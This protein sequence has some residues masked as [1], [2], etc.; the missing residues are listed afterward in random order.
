MVPKF[1]CYAKTTIYVPDTSVY[2]T[3]CL[4]DFFP[5]V[6]DT[7]LTP[8]TVLL[9]LDGAWCRIEEL[10]ALKYFFPKIFIHVCLSNLWRTDIL[11]VEMVKW[12]WLASWIFFMGVNILITSG[13]VFV[14]NSISIQIQIQ[15]LYFHHYWW[16][17]MYLHVMNIAKYN[18]QLIKMYEETIKQ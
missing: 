9:L 13:W 14:P 16:Y 10:N 11:W 12:L 4:N 17:E 3:I 5:S 2:I 1:E 7:R 15:N 8:C 18:N 6:C